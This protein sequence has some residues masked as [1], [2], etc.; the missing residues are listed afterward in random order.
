MP[1]WV[2]AG[3]HSGRQTY[4]GEDLIGHDVNVASRVADVAGPAEVLISDATLQA[5]GDKLPDVEFDEL[6]PVVMKGLPEP[7]RLYRAISFS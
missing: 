5:I 4:R 6:G 1:L 3:V 2:R 7:M